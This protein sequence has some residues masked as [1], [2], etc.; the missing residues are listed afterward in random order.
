[1]TQ[2]FYRL[3]F[4]L[5]CLVAREV[6]VVLS[7][8]WYSPNEESRVPLHQ[9][10]GELLAEGSYHLVLWLACLARVSSCQP[11]HLLIGNSMPASKG[12]YCKRDEGSPNL[13]S[14]YI[15]AFAHLH[16]CAHL[17]IFTSVDIAAVAMVHSNGF[18][19]S[20]HFMS[21]FCHPWVHLCNVMKSK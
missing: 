18:L 1:M 21:G 9:E 4:V 19:Q 10:Q 20:C 2:E 11:R 14:V 15:C 12:V 16:S 6:I 5:I 13:T 8:L 3:F 7:W 17:N